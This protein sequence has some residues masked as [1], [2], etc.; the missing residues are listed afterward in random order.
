MRMPSWGWMAEC[1]R[2]SLRALLLGL[3]FSSA[4]AADVHDF[5]FGDRLFESVG[6]DDDIPYGV[7]T[8]ILQEP[9]GLFWIGT[10]NGLLRFD[11][12][13]FRRYVH[14]PRDPGSLSGDFVQTLAVDARGRLWV[15]T[16][17]DGVS[18][19]DPATDRFTR[20]SHVPERRDS[21]G[22]GP[23]H[24]I[25]VAPDG[26]VWIAA[27]AGLVRLDPKT[28]TFTSWLGEREGLIAGPGVRVQSLLFDRS[29]T[30]WVGT[31]DG[32]ARV[33]AGSAAVERVTTHGS[34]ALAGKE[35]S[36]LFEDSQGQ[37]WIGTREHGAVVL[38]PGSGRLRWIG[39]DH[40]A[41][42]ALSRTWIN[43]IAQPSAD[44]IWLSRFSE[45]IVVV[46]RDSGAVRHLLRH[47]PATASGLAFDAVGVMYVDHSGLLWVGTW[48]GGLQRHNPRNLAIRLLRHSPTEPLRL[49]HA[50]VLRILELQ[51]GRLLAGSTGNGIDIIDRRRGVI[52]G[53]RPDP[54][55]PEA[56]ASG[57]VSGLAQ[58]PQGTVWVGTYQSGVHRQDPG[59]SGFRRYTREHGL[60]TLQIEYL[61]VA[62]N[63]VLWVGTGDGLLRF[64]PERDRF[65]ALTDAN[66]NAPQVRVNGFAE[67]N[68]GRLWIATS[69]GLYAIEPGG[70]RLRVL[71][72]R[73]GADGELVSDH[74]ASVLV[75]GRGRL[76]VDTAKGLQRL[77]REAGREWFEDLSERLG[78]AGQGL[79]GSLLEDASGRI[80]SPL[81]VFD[82]EAMSIYALHRADG[83]DIGAH[84]IGAAARTRDGHLLFGGSTGLAVI[85][86]ERF[87]PWREDPRVLVSG[88]TIDGREQPLGVALQG[89]HL[90]SGQ[91]RFGI[92]FSAAD[93]AAPQ[94]NRYEYR[95]L[96]DSE[97]WIE[98][99]ADHRLASFSNL[100]PGEYVLEMRARNRVGDASSVPTRLRVDVAPLW[101]QTIWFAVALLLLVVVLALGLVR[102]SADRYRRRALVLQ[103]LVDQ[104][105]RELQAFARQ[106]EIASQTDLLSGLGNRRSI[107]NIVPEKVAETLRRVVAQGVDSPRLAFLVVDIDGFKAIN[108]RYGH[109]AG[110]R[111]IER[112]GAVI[113]GCLDKADIAA[114]WGGEEFLVV[115]PVA[116]EAEAW[117]RA[118]ALRVA[119]AETDHAVATRL[120]VSIG[121]AC[122]PFDPSQP[123][124]PGWEQ[125]VEI[126]DAAMYVAKH[127]GRN[128]AYA[129]RATAAMPADFI[130]RF[131]HDPE[132]AAQVLPVELLRITP[133]D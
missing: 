129:F 107:G 70:D 106:A 77:H 119:V 108:D 81:Y 36:T 64:D 5:D 93:F 49:S 79:G 109:R 115:A 127:E 116:D 44:E 28:G 35:I 113:Q 58:D 68:D 3:A 24:A 63:G 66:G 41:A 25:A 133:A 118:E 75:D 117:R 26:S 7:V 37:L 29:G 6:D 71:Q 30:L 21:I 42:E 15:G 69:G 83:I 10:Q 13:R 53:Y 121:A 46:D 14:D 125:V 16:E 104:R 111:V 12:Y 1:W 95:L 91:R 101:W 34:P 59:R 90:A 132:A 51:D 61:Y 43:A 120:T 50:S 74:V 55:D 88:L 22:P 32:L 2:Q 73:T 99:D 124:T 57:V 114:R 8:R 4:V 11:G 98:V 33:R 96:G 126:A 19:L 40:P 47:D 112:I 54:A 85:A 89:L 76:W 62:R 31:R 9:S 80:W 78:M 122:L 48:G 65:V 110:D 20:Y 94:A 17:A 100:W 52:G 105:T 123:R 56:L 82:P 45:G 86:P 18:V 92:E 60:P 102:F 39:R 87:L 130:E 38:D 72:R 128:R 97:Q 23:I 131:R 103:T 67:E 27:D 84:W